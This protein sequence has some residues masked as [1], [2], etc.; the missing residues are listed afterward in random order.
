M[1]IRDEY[2]VKRFVNAAKD[3]CGLLE[4]TPDDPEQWLQ[5]ILN[6]LSDLYS[7]AHH[8]SEYHFDQELYNEDDFD[9]TS[10]ETRRI[11]S[12]VM[13]LLKD[14]VW[15]WAYFDP[16]DPPDSKEEPVRGNLADD[17]TDIYRDIKPGLKAW[18]S[19]DDKLLPEIVFGWR[20][21]LCASHWGVHAVSAMRALHHLCYLRGLSAPKGGEAQEEHSI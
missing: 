4:E 5:D 18:D 12:K 16:S 11:I 20:F 10:E 2:S 17:L 13:T 3:Y 15:Y 1:N 8:L 9:V 19:M 6:S 14:Q 7:S 21:P